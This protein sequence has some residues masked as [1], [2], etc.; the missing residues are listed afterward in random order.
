MSWRFSVGREVTI[1]MHACMHNSPK[2]HGSISLDV[3]YP[4]SCSIADSMPK[5]ASAV[6][7]RDYLFMRFYPSKRL[8]ELITGTSFYHEACLV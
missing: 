2:P 6:I 5:S 3:G 1:N 7:M 8:T 4:I